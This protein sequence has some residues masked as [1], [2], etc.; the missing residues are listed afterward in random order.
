MTTA[1]ELSALIAKTVEEQ[2]FSLDGVKAISAIRDRA[3]LLES[4]LKMARDEGVQSSE[5]IDEL[6]ATVT[7]RDTEL[8]VFKAREAAL[9]AREKQIFELE[10]KA[11]V[12]EA[13]AAAIDGVVTK[14]FANRIIRESAQGFAPAGNYNGMVMSGSTSN[15][16]T[17]EEA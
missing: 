11:A 3:V 16:V 5:K 9:E 6:R 13:K 14:V 10:K 7:A 2:T 4:E 15:N 17:R 1:T 12:A 8:N